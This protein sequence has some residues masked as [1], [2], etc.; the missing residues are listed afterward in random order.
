LQA[1]C[2]QLEADSGGTSAAHLARQLHRV[3]A[4]APSA[5]EGQHQ[6]R[7]AV[8]GNPVVAVA[9]LIIIGLFRSLVLLFAVDE[10]PALIGLHI[11]GGNVA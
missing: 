11:G 10:I 1:V 4:R 3:L 8:D 6:L 9:N 7:G 2:G 5:H